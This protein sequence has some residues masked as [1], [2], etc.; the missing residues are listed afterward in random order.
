M[1]MAIAAHNNFRL[2]SVDIRAAFLQS[3]VLDINVY[4]KPP[5]D[6]RKP[7]LIWRLKKHLYGILQ[8]LVES[9]GGADRDESSGFRCR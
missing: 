4:V 3:K 6:F 5:E 7:G 8:I 2:G 9:E 1:L